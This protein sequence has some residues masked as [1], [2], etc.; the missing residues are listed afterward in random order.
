MTT[1]ST[2]ER[3]RRDV[4][5]TEQIKAIHTGSGGVYGSPRVHAMLKR[6]GVHVGR[7]RVERLM[8]EA[9]LA[10]LSPRRSGFTRRDP[11]TALAP[12]LV[13]RDFTA[14]GPNRLWVTDLTMIPTVEG[15]LW[16]SAKT[17][18]NLG[19]AIPLY[20]QTLTD[21]VRVLGEN[22]PLTA[23]VRGNLASARIKR[24]VDVPK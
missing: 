20:E 7:K 10:G 14:Q 17:V 6:E 18:G 24:A 23:A 19:R 21:T 12:D 15:P 22:H 1:R 8:R 4:E 16:L 5:L 3:R 2:C 11:K 9:G 13:N